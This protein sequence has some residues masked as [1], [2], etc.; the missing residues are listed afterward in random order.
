M[1]NMWKDR[2]IKQENVKTERSAKEQIMREI[3]L[4]ENEQSVEIIERAKGGN[5]YPRTDSK[6]KY[7]E[8]NKYR[9]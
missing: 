2:I 7:E 6:K 4:S 8:D 5:E 9:E 3:N 1:K